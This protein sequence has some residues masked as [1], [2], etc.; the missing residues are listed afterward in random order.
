MYTKEM[1]ITVEKTRHIISFTLD[2]DIHTFKQELEQIP[3]N[4]K[5]EDV[6]DDGDLY[7]LR[8]IE[9]NEVPNE[10]GS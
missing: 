10:K 4:A 8:F 3:D 7:E 2:S 9:T 5:L 1:I 6:I